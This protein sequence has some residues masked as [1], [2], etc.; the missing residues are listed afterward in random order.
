VLVALGGAA[1]WLL[2]Q[3]GEPTQR[4]TIDLEEVRKLAE[5]MPGEKPA[6]VRFEKVATFRMPT[7]AVVAG[8]GFS[9]TQMPVFAWQLRWTDHTALVDTGMD[10]AATRE[11]GG[12]GFDAQAFARIQRAIDASDFVVLTHEHF[13]HLGSL[14][15]AKDPAKALAHVKLTVEQQGHP[16]KMEPSHFSPAVLAQVKPL[17]YDRVTAVAPGVVLLKSPGHTPGSQMVYVRRA[18]GREVLFLGDIAWHRDNVDR[19]T[20]R[21]RLVSSVFLQ[22]DREGVLAQLAALHE[23]ALKYPQLSLVPGHDG[24]AVDALVAAGVVKPGFEQP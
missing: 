11:G 5:S 20:P 23:L 13:D 6:D 12:E 19:V 15:G 9:P 14:A 3:H 8:D 22:E 2:F 24:P 16:E 1:W 18:D 7:T 10:E 17:A 21:A 4:F